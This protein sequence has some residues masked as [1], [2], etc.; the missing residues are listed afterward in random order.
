MSAKE[1][2]HSGPCC[3]PAGAPHPASLALANQPIEKA[4]RRA[5]C[6]TG[7]RLAPLRDE[8][9]N[10]SGEQRDEEADEK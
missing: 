1:I 8:F 9:E 2:S 10:E 7:E 6:G 5:G 4:L 3:L